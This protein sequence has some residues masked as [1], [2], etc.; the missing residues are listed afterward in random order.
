TLTFTINP[1][2][3]CSITSFNFWRQRS[4]TGAQNWSMTINGIS[5]GSGT[6]PTS[7]A[8]IGVTSVAN[9]VTNQSNTITVILSLSG[10]TGSGTFRID[11]FTLNGTVTAVAGV[12]DPASFS[13]TPFSATQIDLSA[14]ANINGNN[15]VVVSNGSGTFGTPAP[16]VAAPSAGNAYVGGTVVYNGTAAGL[17]SHT[18]LNPSSL[19]YY[20]AFSYDGS[21]NF[22]SGL[23]ANGITYKAEPSEHATLFACGTTT[24][25][26]IPL[27]WTDG[28]GSVLADGY[29]IKWSSVSFAAISD[30]ADLIA[31]AN[32]P[33]AMNIP[34]ATQIAN[35]SG[36][37]P[38]TTY[39]FKIYA[40]TN[41]GNK[42]DYKTDGIISSTSCATQTGPI[43]AWQFGSPASLGNEATYSATTLD[44]NLNSS[45]LSRGSGVTATALGRAFSATNFDVGGTKA[46]A[47]SNNE[48][49]QFTVNASTGCS[50]SLSTLDARLRRSGATSPNTYIWQ[51]SK[52]GINF[53]D[54]GS[55][56]SF[57]STVDGVDQAT[58]ILSGI[59][60][61]QN[62]PTTKT[63]TFRLYAWGGSNTGSTFAIGR[64]G[65]G[66]T[67]NS[68]A[69]GGAVVPCTDPTPFTVNG[70]G[71]FCSGDPGVNV[72]LSG[73]ETGISYQMQI[74]GIDSGSPFI[75]DGN[76]I[77]FGIQSTAGTYTVIATA[78]LGCTTTMSGNAIVVVNSLP[79]PSISGTLSI[80]AGGSTTLDAGS[81][82]SYSW[83]TGA[84][85]Q[86]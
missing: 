19:F 5:V 32:G 7:G 13:A 21:N 34:A 64:F 59:T 49:F 3:Q 74:D 16:G 41:S 27:S 17:T 82:S 50:V 71:S 39:F 12:L 8:A 62:V 40:Y 51:F 68:L 75:G 79:T 61:L 14:T 73:S 18:G 36:L 1:G 20:K 81:Y 10:A 37:T 29:L 24:Q 30:P 25:T 35:I 60:E 42:I 6:S 55:D 80:C 63:I 53:T 47:I 4:N 70:G 65:T 38:T 2:Y 78:P 31:E 83:S 46:T 57:T 11:D 28:A 56:I 52:D 26:S 85:T 44:A 22:S 66:V 43:L 23:T 58:I 77:N 45:S 86:T 33:S 54:I 15:I 69:I 84:T 72:G 67:S 76:P 48:Y 9:P